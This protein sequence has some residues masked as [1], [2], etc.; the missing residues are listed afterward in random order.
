MTQ[1]VSYEKGQFQYPK[2]LDK[3]MKNVLEQIGSETAKG[4]ISYPEQYAQRMDALLEKV[5]NLEDAKWY[6]YWDLVVNNVE[7]ISDQVIRDLDDIPDKN[8]K[9]IDETIIE[10]WNEIVTMM[11]KTYTEET[12]DNGNSRETTA[13]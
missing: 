7:T 12:K 11:E 2:Y 9:E 4:N 13:V 10:G 1:E 3:R 8:Q 6:S 5:W